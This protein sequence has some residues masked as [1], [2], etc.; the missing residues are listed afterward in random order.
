MVLTAII[1]PASGS[2]PPDAQALL[3]AALED[4]GESVTILQMTP[5]CSLPEM[6]AEASA[7]SA[8]AVIV[9]AGDGTVAAVLDAAGP[10]G[11]PV[12]ALPGGTMNLLHKAIHGEADWKGCLTG[13]LKSGI[14]LSIPAGVVGG[15]RFYVAA[16]V[17]NLTHLA[18]SREALRAGR[19]LEA[20]AALG[21]APVLDLETVLDIRADR[22]GEA[23]VM[24]LPATAAAILPS[25]R[26][27]GGL[28]VGVID[29]G[30]FLELTATGL[31]AMFRD[32]R[33]LDSVSRVLAQTVIVEH[34]LGQEIHATLDGEVVM[35]PSRAIFSRIDAA[36]RVL[37]ARDE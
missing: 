5:G 23:G 21:Q 24:H 10:D 35:L 4:L 20:V 37:S 19:P 25:G 30:N 1:N 26:L 34:R 32:W 14:S 13:A 11:A 22:G 9:W 28:E 31:A 36:A 12:L 29:P 16:M 18:E 8:D 2:V 27:G 17:G 7:S 15:R 6:F 33:E 3:E